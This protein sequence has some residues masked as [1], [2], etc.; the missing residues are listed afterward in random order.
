MAAVGAGAG[1]CA[2]SLSVRP[3]LT[4]CLLLASDYAGAAASSTHDD[5]DDDDD[6][7]KDKELDD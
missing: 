2:S 4:N 5:D 7:A 3:V 1:E 6:D